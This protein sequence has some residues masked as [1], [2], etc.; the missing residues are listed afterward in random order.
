MKS[1]ISWDSYTPQNNQL[2][3]AGLYNRW[4]MSDWIMHRALLIAFSPVLICMAAY[5][6][7]RLSQSLKYWMHI[8][9]IYHGVTII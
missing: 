7:L 3:V 1:S 8:Y 4:C 6:T 9:L 5:Y 2:Q